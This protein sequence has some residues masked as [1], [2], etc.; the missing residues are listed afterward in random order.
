MP[1]PNFRPPA[2]CGIRPRRSIS[3]IRFVELCPQVAVKWNSRVKT[4]CG[5]LPLKAYAGKTGT[6]GKSPIPNAG[7][8]AYGYFGEAATIGKSLTPNAGTV[9]YGYA[10]KTGTFFKSRLTNNS[11]TIL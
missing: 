3:F 5:N 4:A 10:G 8:I 1:T 6:R 11:N 7:A 9:W 2:L